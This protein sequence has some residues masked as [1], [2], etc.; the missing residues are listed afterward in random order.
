MGMSMKATVASGAVQG[1]G[2]SFTLDFNP[3]L[4]FPNRITHAQYSLIATNGAFPNHVLRSVSNNRVVVAAN[5]PVSATSYKPSEFNN[6]NCEK[7]GKL[8]HFPKERFL[9]LHAFQGGRRAEYED[10]SEALTRLK[11]NSSI[12]LYQTEF[13]NLSHQHNG[14]SKP[15]LVGDF[16]AESTDDIHLDVN[17]KQPWTL[18]DAIG[19]AWFVEEWN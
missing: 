13:K 6:L 19:V 1:N 8:T 15:Y 17:I 14:F 4:L 3:V 9:I 11:Q 5:V 12:E 18:T 16:I 7:S 10:P 2:T